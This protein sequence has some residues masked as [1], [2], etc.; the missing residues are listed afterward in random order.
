MCSLPGSTTTRHVGS[1]S[2]PR[3]PSRFLRILFFSSRWRAWS[4]FDIAATV[5][6]AS[7]SSSSFR[8]SRRLRIVRKLVSVPPSQRSVTYGMP[9]RCA[10]A[11]TA[12]RAE[13]FVPTK[14]IFPPSDG[15]LLQEV[16]RAH[17]PLHRLLEVDDV[18]R[19]ALAVDE[20]LH[21]RVPPAG[22]VAEVNAA[23]EQFRHRDDRQERTPKVGRGPRTRTR[24]RLGGASD[25]PRAGEAESRSVSGA[26]KRSSRAG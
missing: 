16:R 9:V 15:D 3:M 11:R 1:A 8:R 6:F 18:D 7:R 17:E 14:R 12:S 22:A 21:L 26:R 20:R 2:R 5:P 13:R 24:P 4:F 23:L 25:S 19:V 10:A